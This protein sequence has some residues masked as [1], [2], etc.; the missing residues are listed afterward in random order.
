MASDNSSHSNERAPAR[1][2]DVVGLSSGTAAVSDSG[3]AL[4][5]GESLSPLNA[6]GTAVLVIAAVAL[7][8]F[9]TE[10]TSNLATTATMLP[11][12]GA[13]ALQAGVPPLVLTVPI[14]I[15]A[16]CAFMLPVATPPNTIVFASGEVTIRQ[17]VRAG[18]WLNLIAVALITLLTFVVI[19]PMWME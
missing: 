17:M 10:L 12:M 5:L 8:I 6:W 16:S 2:A 3:L 4:W 13:I 15:A 11:V 14:T 7:V 9:L 1:S 19:Q 18:L